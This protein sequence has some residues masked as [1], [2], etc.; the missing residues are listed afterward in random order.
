MTG[1]VSENEWL[2][3]DETY[4]LVNQMRGESDRKLRLIG[5]AL[6]R[7]MWVRLPN[8]SRRAI[9]IAEQFADGLADEKTR[10]RYHRRANAACQLSSAVCPHP[11][12]V[13]AQA[14]S[15]TGWYAAELTVGC[16]GDTMMEGRLIRDIFGNPFRP[17]TLNPNWLSPTVQNL[18]MSIYTERE[19]DRM[20]ILADALE[21]A[22]CTNDDIL[23]HCR[24]GQDHVR[25]CWVLDLVL[26]KE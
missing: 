12:W 25:G 23:D 16:T 10:Q 13:A 14:I 9:E 1:A 21:D 6:S 26:G 20:P 15:Q 17:V 19:F 8:I 24:T 3:T 5:C 11:Q 18:A 4:R 22:G 2:T 7:T